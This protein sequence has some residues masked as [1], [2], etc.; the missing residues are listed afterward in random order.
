MLT[1]TPCC[2]SDKPNDGATAPLNTS[3]YNSPVCHFTDLQNRWQRK[4]CMYTAEKTQTCNRKATT[5][6]EY[7]VGQ[8][9]TTCH[10]LGRSYIR[11]SKKSPCAVNVIYRRFT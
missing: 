10:L 7:D 9:M 5:T 3:V 8:S 6:I 1:F 4:Q 11:M 2:D